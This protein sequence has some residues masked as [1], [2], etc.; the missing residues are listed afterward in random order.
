MLFSYDK[1]ETELLQENWCKE[2]EFKDI[3]T[4]DKI[5]LEAVFHDLNRGY[6]ISCEGSSDCTLESDSKFTYFSGNNFYCED[7]VLRLY[8]EGEYFIFSHMC[9]T[10]NN[11][12]VVVVVKP[13]DIWAED[14]V[15]E[16]EIVNL[17]PIYYL[18]EY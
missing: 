2:K 4:N 8:I 3:T 12:I 15:I 7:D 9:V 5:A 16:E 10:T 6:F 18:V 1:I 14:N 11:K 13:T 17:E